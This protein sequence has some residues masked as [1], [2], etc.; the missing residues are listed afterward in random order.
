M[1]RVFAM[2][3]IPLLIVGCSTPANPPAVPVTLTPSEILDKVAKTYASL[4]SYKAEGTITSDVDT[5][6]IKVT[7]ETSFSILL[8][9]PHF[10]LISWSQKMPMVDMTQSGTVWNDGTSPYFY[11]SATNSYS[12]MSDDSMALGA[13]TG[14]SSG[15]ANTIPSYFFSGSSGQPSV[16]L[17]LIDP[18]LETTETI[19]EDD[20]YVVSGS[21][22]VSKKESLWI[23]KQTF[24]IKKVSRSLEQPAGGRIASPE[25]TDEQLE[26]AMKLTGQEVT[27]ES[28]QQMKEMMKSATDM[29]KLDQLKGSFTEVFTTISTPEVSPQDFQFSPPKDTVLNDFPV[30]ANPVENK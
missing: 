5:G 10:Y 22:P 9:R 25:M 12:K 15:A 16:S 28:K 30:S 19:G 21:S 23:S 27:D 29:V 2:A 8:A 11:M 18:Q 4:K 6:Q 20:C 26:E 1:I 13:A 3:M 17:R 24:L 14:V 7:L